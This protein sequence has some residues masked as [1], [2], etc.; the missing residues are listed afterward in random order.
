LRPVGRLRGLGGLEAAAALVAR[1][2]RGR[3]THITYT[4]N[5]CRGFRDIGALR[6][7]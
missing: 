7:R 5:C 4:R 6:Q 1:K 3:D 2:A